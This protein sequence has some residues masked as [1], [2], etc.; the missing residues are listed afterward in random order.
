MLSWSL[1]HCGDP[2]VGSV[3]TR[4]AHN[5]GSHKITEPVPII[6]VLKKK[7][8]CQITTYTIASILP[9]FHEKHL[10]WSGFSYTWFCDFESTQKHQ[11]RRLSKNANPTLMGPYSLRCW[12][13]RRY[14]MAKCLASCCTLNFIFNIVFLFFFLHKWTSPLQRKPNTPQSFLGGEV[15]TRGK[16]HKPSRLTTKLNHLGY[17]VT[18]SNFQV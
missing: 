4:R 18:P 1:C 9:V 10:L 12:G 2:S 11:N 15:P 8:N 3:P 14:S 6:T 16:N 13:K 5:S 7:L 17:L